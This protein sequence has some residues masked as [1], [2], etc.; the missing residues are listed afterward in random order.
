MKARSLTA[1]ADQQ[2]A[3]SRPSNNPKTPPSS[4]DR[5][6]IHRHY[7]ASAVLRAHPPPCRPS[8]PL[9]GFRLV[10][11]HHRQ[12]F[13]CCLHPPLPCVPPPLP[14]W[15]RPVLASF[16]SRPMAAFPGA[17]A[18]RLPHHWFRG[19][20]G[21]HCTLR[22][23]WSLSRPRR[24]VTSKCFKL[25]RYLHNSLRLLPAG[26]TFAGR[27]LHPLKDGAFHGTPCSRR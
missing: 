15:D 16:A 14:R 1:L 19:L 26:T 20:L 21:V 7:P 5:A 24:P 11:A 18:G 2:S 9:T 6:L 22:P 4:N 27:D 25:C 8:L 23:A 12:G 13:P 10:C 3:A 17:R